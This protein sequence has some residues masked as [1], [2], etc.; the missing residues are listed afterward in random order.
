M[1]VILLES[2]HS[3]LLIGDLATR[4]VLLLI[5]GG[6]DLEPCLRRGVRDEAYDGFQ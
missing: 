6:T 5:R 1:E 3:H 2:E 4:V